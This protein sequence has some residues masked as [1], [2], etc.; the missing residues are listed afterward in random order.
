M[1]ANSNPDDRVERA[2]LKRALGYRHTEIYSEEIVDRKTGQPTGEVKK[3]S[4]TKF[5]PPDVRAAMTWLQNRRPDRWK[6]APPD[7]R[8]DEIETDPEDTNLL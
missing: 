2:L 7:L 4:V 3:R 1:S 5:V 6:C 8:D